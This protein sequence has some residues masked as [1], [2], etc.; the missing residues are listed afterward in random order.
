[1][2]IESETS[3]APEQS[4]GWRGKF[5]GV[6]LA[7]SAFSILWFAAAAVGTKLGLWTWQF[8]LGKMTIGW[9]PTLLMV[10]AGISVL[11]V[12][13]SLIKAPRKRAFMLAAAA[14]LISGLA[15]GRVAAFGAGAAR[16][17]PLHDIQ[18]DWS[19]P[20]QPSDALSVEREATGALNP[21]ED[22]PVII[23]AANGRWPGM[24]GR[25]VAEVQEEAEF[26]PA[27]HKSPKQTPYPKI[28]PLVTAA[29]PDA[30]YAAALA[31]AESRGWTIVLADPED[32]L[33][34]ATEESFWFGFKDDIMIRVRSEGEGSRIDIRS[35]S[36]VGLSD[37]GANAKRV[38]NLLDE[39]ETRLGKGA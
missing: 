5:A 16:L 29:A 4:A 24:G 30:A 22:D 34:D 28:A 13:V 27:I 33:I 35:T 18:T 38:R 14:L 11:A 26:D 7:L 8:G 1:M 2:T 3:T 39:I 32:G 20:I 17:P 37:L 36:R 9:G 15:F 31:A 19:D 12:I 6:A 21:V 25:R 23:D 10:A